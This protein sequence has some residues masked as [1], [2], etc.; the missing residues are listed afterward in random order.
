M[1][2]SKDAGEDGWI[3]GDQLILPPQSLSPEEIGAFLKFLFTEIARKPKR[4]KLRETAGVA[5][6]LKAIAFETPASAERDTAERLAEMIWLTML[7]TGQIEITRKD[8]V[9]H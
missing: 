7:D 3:R 1:P 4:L 2:P 6:Y 8:E 5:R 9:I